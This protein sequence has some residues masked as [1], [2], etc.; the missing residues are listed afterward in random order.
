MLFCTTAT[1]WHGHD[2][3]DLSD[4]RLTVRLRARDLDLKGAKIYLH[5]VTDAGRFHYII[6]PIF[7]V[8]DEIRWETVTFA[9]AGNPA[10]WF[11]SWSRDGNPAGLDRT[12]VTWIGLGFLGHSPD[13]PPTGIIEIGEIRL[14]GWR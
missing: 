1:A 14:D 13:A 8:F 3:I 7:F 11:K 5:V 2:Y 12:R 4:A 9:I 10:Y 6:I